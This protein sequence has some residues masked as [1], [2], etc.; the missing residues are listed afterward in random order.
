[1]KKKEKFLPSALSVAF[2]KTETEG[3]KQAIKLDPDYSTDFVLEYDN[4]G[5]II[6]CNPAATQ[7]LGYHRHEILNRHFTEFVSK[8]HVEKVIGFYQNQFKQ[9]NEQCYF[10]FKYLTKN[11]KEYWV[12][13]KSILILNNGWI[14]GVKTIGIDI[15]EKKTMG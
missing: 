10:E 6:Y 14:E 5:Y 1:M 3:I 8:D 11:K 2:V 7:K 9:K 4:E 13:Q 15:T 12:G